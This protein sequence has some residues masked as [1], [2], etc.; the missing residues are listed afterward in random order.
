MALILMLLSGCHSDVSHGYS[1]RRETKCLSAWATVSVSSS[2]LTI[3][4]QAKITTMDK[5]WGDLESSETTGN[6]FTMSPNLEI[7][8]LL[9][10]SLWCCTHSQF[11]EEYSTIDSQRS[12]LSKES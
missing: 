8:I 9:W 11:L 2:K 3:L 1:K 12:D 10:N 6:F 5:A 7:K 4:F